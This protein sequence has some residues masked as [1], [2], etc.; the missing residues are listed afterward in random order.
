MR[1]MLLTGAALAALWA[2]AACS[3]SAGRGGSQSRPP[4]AVE[5]E[6]AAAGDFLQSVEVV[7]TLEPRAQAAVK[8]EVTGTVTEVLVT[9]W[10]PVRKGQVLAR[11]DQRE[12]RAQLLQVQAEAAR[13]EREY[14]RALKLKE[15][16]LMTAQGLED[17]QTQRETARALKDL[18]AT[19]LDKLVVRSPMDGVISFRGV[20]EGDRVEGMG[21]GPMFRIVDT[22][23]FDLTVLVPASTIHLVRVG[24]PLSFATEA[25]PG[26]TFKGT[27]SHINPAADPVS[28]TVAVQSDVPNTTGELRAGLFAKGSILCGNR[29]GVLQVPR[30]ALLAWDLQARRAK[31]F[32]AAGG[33]ARQREVR[34]GAVS[35][36]RVEV[37]EGLAPGEEVV[38]RGAFDLQDGDRIL[39]RSERGS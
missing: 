17:A 20:S 31:V 26:R 38:T 1:S 29:T 19:K 13:A 4:V 6:R 39:V 25:V 21:G 23:R 32:V 8:S 36:G 9:Q 12:S 33:V 10:V 3:Q 27:V 14:G 2:V 11:L 15:A 16:G 7:G 5:T 34:T 24:Q 35:G 30:E 37:A 22:R 18:A 28:R